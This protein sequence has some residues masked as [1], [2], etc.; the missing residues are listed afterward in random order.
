MRA[1]AF[2][3]GLPIHQHTS[4]DIQVHQPEQGER[5]PVVPEDLVVTLITAGH[6]VG[7][8]M[9]LFEGSKGRCRLK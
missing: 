9:F 7:S 4:I 5:E 2:V 1:R 3:M 8:L 6:C